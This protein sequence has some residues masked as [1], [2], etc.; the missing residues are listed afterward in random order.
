LKDKV[1][2]V[3]YHIRNILSSKFLRKVTS[4]VLKK[5]WILLF[6]RDISRI[7]GRISR[8]GRGMIA[9]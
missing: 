4:K 2:D 3:I 9:K 6:A 7:T 5:R 8:I 1:Y